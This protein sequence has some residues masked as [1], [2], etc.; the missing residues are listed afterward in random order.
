MAS[1]TS[2]T[3]GI[4]AIKIAKIDAFGN[5][6]TLSLQE[7]DTLVIEFS[8][9]GRVEFTIT[10]I[11]EYPNYYLYYVV[12][13]QLGN[14][15]STFPRPTSLGAGGSGFI[16]S[17]NINVLP[18]SSLSP[19]TGYLAGF[20][21]L[22]NISPYTYNNGTGVFTSPSWS[23]AYT[24]VMNFT[25]SIFTNQTGSTSLFLFVSSS[26][27][28]A[29]FLGSTIINIPDNISGSSNARTI[30]ASIP[31]RVTSGNNVDFGLRLGNYYGSNTFFI[32]TSSVTMSLVSYVT[33]ST[34]TNNDLTV[35]EP[36]L[37]EDFFFSDYN[38]LAG[39][40]V[41]ARES[42]FY[43]DVDFASN[44]ITAV[45]ENSILNDTAT[46]AA[47][48]HSNYTSARQINSRYVGKELTSARLNEW[49]QGDVSY[50]KTPNVSNPEVN[51]VYFNYAGGTS[52][53][54]GNQ[55]A[56]RTQ[57]NIR[58]IVDQNGNV[59]KPINDSDGINL[60][61]IQQTFE[62]N[63]GATL[64]LDDNDT[65]G[66]NLAALNGSW[67]IFKSGYKIT[68]IIYTQTASYDNN[69][70]VVGYGY[71]SS[72][73]FNQ[74]EQGPDQTKNNYMMYAAGVDDSVILTDNTVQTVQFSQP[75]F[76]GSFANFNVVTS[77]Y[78]PTGSLAQLSSS[79]Y[80]LDFKAYIEVKENADAIVTYA[81]QRSTNNGGNWFTI[82]NTRQINYNNTLTGQ[83]FYSE[84]AATTSTLYR[85]AAV[86]S[87][88]GFNSLNLSNNSYFQVTQ[89]P[90][91]GTGTCTNITAPFWTTGSS[92]NILLASTASDGLNN[93]YSQRQE[94]IE[95]SGFNPIVED[96]ELKTN[97][98]IRFES[99]ENLAF[100]INN[101][102][103]SATGQLILKLDRNIPNG[104][105]LNFFLVR[106]YVEDPS[107]IIL[108]VNK[109]AGAS[110]GGVLKPQYISSELTNNLDSIIQNLKNQNL[111]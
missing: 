61:T 94:S 76:S 107:S 44:Q 52:P 8:D 48:Q 93:Y 63:L 83:I 67:P 82:G 35:L 96:F 111:I 102:T 99:L 7:L 34:D 86:N 13:K 79:G 89:Y 59:T 38:V 23:V 105:N 17:G 3:N 19:G 88:G 12:V 71:T 20:T 43:M 22:N 91:P 31:F 95:R 92:A 5:N 75:V 42:D 21:G 66:V 56:D 101:V 10:S 78:K 2:I 39:N 14:Q 103:S 26:T 108:E 1:S 45:N 84:I 80:I 58:Y 68:P 11:A 65:F 41:V 100:V 85:I 55:N 73:L 72:I 54:W 74:G 53:E 50:G 15:N 9:L 64:V 51:F 110:S 81:L 33:S 36:Y 57:I 28:T 60:G 27:G 90:N 62:E 25:C 24:D 16:A 49:T 47:V 32:P 37:S 46:R 29:G 69:G 40:A 18:Y 87:S 109:P 97:D 106:R 70:N 30:S 104:T 98:E 77:S 4:K 6:N